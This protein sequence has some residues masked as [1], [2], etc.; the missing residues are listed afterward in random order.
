M[1][2]S[3]AG[4]TV[5]LFAALLASTA[6]LGAAAQV[7]GTAG[8][9]TAV[10]S[11]ANQTANATTT[12]TTQADA[13]II[14]DGETLVLQPKPNQTIRGETTAEPGTNLTVQIQGEQ[15]IRTDVAT[16]TDEGT[17][18]VTL[19]LSSAYGQDLHIEVHRGDAQLAAAEGRVSCA[20]KCETTEAT[21]G[22]WEQTTTVSESDSLLGQFTGGV[23]MIAVGGVLAVAGIG[24]LLGL[25]RN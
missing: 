24:V 3:R 2:A 14:T 22:S 15:F 6:V 10:P 20:G 12:A 17:F 8:D 18:S 1:T 16:V 7:P 23:G 21:T 4:V 19:D 5:A 25:F 9:V 13:T 11:D